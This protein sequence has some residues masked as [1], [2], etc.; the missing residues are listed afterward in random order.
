MSLTEAERAR[1]RKAI[2]E[3]HIRCENLHDLEAMMATFGM[4]ARYDDE[5]WADHRVGRDGVRSY[6]TELLR[7][8]P[9]LAI[10]VT[11][12]HFASESVVVEVIIHGTHLGPWRGLPA[13]GRR[14]KFPLCGVYWFDASDKLAC[15]RIYYDRGTV[16]GQLGLFHEPVR[17]LGRVVTVLSHPLTIARAYLRLASRDSGKAPSRGTA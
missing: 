5:P 1:A 15:E 4:D 17:G 7:A 11:D 16:M 9:D 10:E 13:T 8:L 2:V 6:Y 12:W 3:E 14:M